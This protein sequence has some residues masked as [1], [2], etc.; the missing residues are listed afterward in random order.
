MPAKTLD[1]DPDRTRLPAKFVFSII[2]TAITLTITATVW[3]VTKNVIDDTQT[4]ENKETVKALA[5]LEDLLREKTHRDDMRFETERAERKNDNAERKTE[6]Q[7]VEKAIKDLGLDMVRVFTE[8]VSKETAREWI[9]RQRISNPN[10]VW[11]DLPGELT[12]VPIPVPVP[13]AQSPA[14]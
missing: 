2:A 4:N 13:A 14:K 8:S 3:V 12:S 6:I 11:H 5:R 10:I 9:L 7:S 1:V